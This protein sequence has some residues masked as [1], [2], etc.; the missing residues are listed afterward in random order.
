VHL[1]DQWGFAT[2]AALHFAQA[3][4]LVDGGFV[5]DVILADLR[6]AEDMDGIRTVDRLRER[7]RRAVPA[8]LIS[9][10]TGAPE[11]A[12]V[13]ESGLLLLTKPVA[14]ARLRSALHALLAAR[15]K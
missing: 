11:L 9:G 6:L 3:C 15:P 2:R 5:P 4:E 7:L 8:L 14:P 10:D 12:R 1:L 13:R